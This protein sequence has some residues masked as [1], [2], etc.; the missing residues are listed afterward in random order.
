MSAA[1]L[2]YTEVEDDLRR[3]VRKLLQDRSDP[4]TIL[5]RCESDQPYDIPLWTTMAAELGLAGL[6]TPEEQG[7]SGA[8]V[9][10]LAV[11]AEELGR[12]VAPVP[13]LGSAALATTALLGCGESELLP[14]LISG[15]TVAT[16]AVPLTTVPHSDFPTSVRATDS[17]LTGTVSAVV[18][19][20]AAQHVVVPAAD[21][22]GPALYVLDIGESGVSVEETTPLDLTRRIGRLVCEGCPGRKIA[23]TDVAAKALRDALVTSAGILASEQVGLAQLC[24]DSTVDYALTR[25]QFGRP[26]GSFQ[27]VKHRLADLWAK[28]ST[29]RATARHAADALSRHEE[30]ELSVA[31]AQAYCSDL[32]VLAAEECLQ[33]HGGIGMTWEH[34]A[35]LYLGRAKS[36]QLS[37]G[38]AER[39]RGRISELV[40]LPA[41]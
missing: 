8:S 13:F 16:L 35:H 40:D 30:I 38:I 14:L 12:S 17:K 41:H 25:Y 1:D 2:L 31:L 15:A 4:T 10:E 19:L 5:A 28:V 23:G 32:V 7:G 36:A 29:A 37:F 21:E 26:I 34:P 3:T 27:A 22:A 18:D 11:V 39:H 6:A 33:L 24:L 20:P 9:R